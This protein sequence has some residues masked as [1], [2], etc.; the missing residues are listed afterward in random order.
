[1]LIEPA[2]RFTSLLESKDTISWSQNEIQIKQWLDQL[3]KFCD[4]FE[5]ENRYL[6]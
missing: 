5:N 3:K 1:M 6:R 4:Q 2:K